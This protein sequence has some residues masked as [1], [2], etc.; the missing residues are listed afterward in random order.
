MRHRFFVSGDGYASIARDPQRVV[1][2]LLW[3]LALADVPALDRYESLS[4]GLYTKTTQPVLT[5]QGARRALVYVGR[6]VRP[7]AAKPGYME[8]V[9][10][11][12]A[13]A[14]LP[15]DYVQGLRPWLPKASTS[16]PAPERVA[17][18]PLWG[19]PAAGSRKPREF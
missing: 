7:G 6:A 14:G 19:A 11:A 12:A 4:T 10:E 9:L 16:T 13:Q 8:E 17:V 3:D 1:W 2:G 5:V 18:R 15:A